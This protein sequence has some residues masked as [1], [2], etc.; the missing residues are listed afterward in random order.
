MKYLKIAFGLVVVAGLMAVVAAPAMATPRWVTCVKGSGK[1]ENSLCVKEGSGGWETKE[2]EGT[3]TITSSGEFELE[4]SSSGVGLVC[5]GTD[6]GWIANLTSRSAAA[7]DGLTSITATSCT[8]IKA[9]SCEESKGVTAK[10]RNLP[11]GGRLVEKGSEVRSE[12]ASGPRK[13]EGNGEPGWSIE[14]TVGG[15]LKITDTCERQGNTV[16]EIARRAEGS[17]EA[18]FDEITKSET[19]ASCTVGGTNTGLVRGTVAIKLT[20]GNASWILAPNLK[21]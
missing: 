16:D 6:T 10:A 9:G 5:K 3:S 21:T 11:W 7:D 8:F 14:C 4:D 17:V 2:L 19:M 12:T 20:N 1:Y 15:V 18:S 13:E